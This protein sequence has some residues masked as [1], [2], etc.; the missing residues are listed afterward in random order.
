MTPVLYVSEPFTYEGGG[1]AAGLGV[2]VVHQDTSIKA[3]IYHDAGVSRAPNPIRTNDVGEAVFWVEPGD[4]DMLANGVRTP[5]EVS[6]DGGPGSYEEGVLLPFTVAAGSGAGQGKARLY[7]D[8]GLQLTLESIRASVDALSG[9]DL[10]VD[11]NMNGLTV[12]TNQANRPSIS[13]PGGTQ[14]VSPD[15]TDVPDGTYFTV[16]VD[17]AGSYTNLVVQ[18]QLK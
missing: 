9:Q 18:I 10:I 11:V 16:D 2:S 12:F 15:V 7:N 13:A 8:T 17:Q 6:G 1:V 3:P 5:I 14:K 4:Y